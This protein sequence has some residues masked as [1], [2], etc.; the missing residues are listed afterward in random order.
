MIKTFSLK[1]FQ[2]ILKERQKK[3]F[4]CNIV[5]SGTRGLGKSTFLFKLLSRFDNFDPWKHQVYSREKV[6]ELLEGQEKGIIFDDEA[7]ASGYKREFHNVSQQKL[8]KMLNMYRDHFNIFAMA[9]PNFYS[10][11]KD[12][13]DVM[14][15]HVHI[16]ER[17]K[18]V[19]HVANEGR[20]YQTDKWDVKINQKKEEKWQEKKK[21]N[22]KY[23]P[24]YHKLTTFRG[25]IKFGDL[26]PKQRELY[27]R[28]KREKRRE[29]YEAEYEENKEKEDP[30][31]AFLKR[32]LEGIQK[33]YMDREKIKAAC[34][35]NNY[36]WNTIQSHLSKKIKKDYP[37]LSL[38]QYIQKCKIE[39]GQDYSTGVAQKNKPVYSTAVAQKGKSLNSNNN[40]NNVPTITFD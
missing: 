20:L 29:L 19:L 37:H 7:I 17:G 16:I 25:Y 31:A 6:I 32:I 34:F 13:R 14:K 27:K 3:E 21:Q 11:D 26:G 30:R 35:T 1:E 33:G 4:D 39:N 10:L 36:D 23:S 38:E 9:I 28:I 24:P 12:I 18:A 2:K 5:V 22:P 8:I 40:K 15:F